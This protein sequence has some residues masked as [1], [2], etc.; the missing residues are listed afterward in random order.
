[1]ADATSFSRYVTLQGHVVDTTAHGAEEHI[2]VLAQRTIDT[3]GP[4]ARVGLRLAHLRTGR[5]PPVREQIFQASLRVRT[6]RMPRSNIVAVAFCVVVSLSSKDNFMT[7][8]VTGAR[9]HVG[10]AV[11]EALLRA[12]IPA[13]SLRAGGRNPERLT[14]P[15]GVAAV[16]ADLDDP[17]GL[18]DALAGVDQVFAYAPGNDPISTFATMAAAGVRHVVLLSSF[19]VHQPNTE[20]D[21]I[22]EYHLAA[23]QALAAT[24]IEATLLRP[25]AFASNTLAWAPEIRERGLVEHAYPDARTTPIHEADIADAAVLAL[26]S[27]HGSPVRGSALELSGPE[28]LT[29]REQV[30]TLGKELNQ[31]VELVEITPDQARQSLLAAD[32]PP[33]M[34]DSIST[35]WVMSTTTPNPVHDL[36]PLTG[37]PG[38]TFATWVRDHPSDFGG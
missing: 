20:G 30:T 38:R 26:T 25:G 27:P 22:A 13:R 35:M 7:V 33:A 34:V 4:P 23:E 16:R 11:L 15:A 37:R 10:G 29:F 18:M 28:S 5:R 9:G 24:E 19:S 2:E 21:P 31:S 14:P 8:L 3:R 12:G 36:R 17:A 1:M 6:D 32:V